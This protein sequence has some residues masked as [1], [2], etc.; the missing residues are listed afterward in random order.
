MVRGRI[1]SVNQ[2]AQTAG[3]GVGVAIGG[4]VGT[5]IGWRWAFLVVGIPG[6]LLAIPA[7]RLREPVRGE[8][9][10]TTVETATP[11]RTA[12]M[13]A[14]ELLPGGGRR[15]AGPAADDLRHP[16]DALRAGR[17]RH[18]AVHGVGHRLVAR[19]L[20]RPLLQHDRGPGRRR[21][22]RPARPRWLVGTLGGGSLADRLYGRVAG[23][24]ILLVGWSIIVCTALY[25]VSYDAP[26]VP[27]VPAR[28]WRCSSSGTTSSPGA[29]PPGRA[30]LPR[31]PGPRSA[32]WCCCSCS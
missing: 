23:G 10:G 1:F 31:P 24:R 17:G 25:V 26:V 19:D 14:R 11:G 9:E 32:Q 2:I 22:R 18:P 29:S 21:H 6:M 16:A 13:S 7:F 28:G 8:A 4:L 27:V 20:P 5:T 12:G 15:P 30:R 3:G